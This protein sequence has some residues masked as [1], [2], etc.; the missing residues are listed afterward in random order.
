ML[1]SSYFATIGDNTDIKDNGKTA[2]TEDDRNTTSSLIH[3]P[4]AYSKTIAERDAWRIAKAQDQ[5]DLVTINP[6][7]VMGQG[8]NPNA[9]SESFNIIKDLANGKLGSCGK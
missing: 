5:W 8:I 1:T 9:T 2:I 7:F 4:Y 3:Q 6:A